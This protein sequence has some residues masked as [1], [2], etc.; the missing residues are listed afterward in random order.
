MAYCLR[1]ACKMSDY[2]ADYSKIWQVKV[3]VNPE[4]G[5]ITHTILLVITHI[6]Y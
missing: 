2:F 1:K 4:M 3:T 6:Y 5:K